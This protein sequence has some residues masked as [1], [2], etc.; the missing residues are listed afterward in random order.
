MGR[1]NRPRAAS[2]LDARHRSIRFHRATR[3]RA[4]RSVL[5]CV[6]VL[7]TGFMKRLKWSTSQVG[8]RIEASQNNGQVLPGGY[9]ANHADV[10][11]YFAIRNGAAQN[12]QGKQQA[13]RHRP[14]L[15][16]R[17]VRICR[18]NARKHSLPHPNYMG[19]SPAILLEM[20]IKIEK[21]KRKSPP[22]SGNARTTNAIMPQAA[23]SEDSP[24]M[25]SVKNIEGIQHA[26]SFLSNLPENVLPTFV[27]RNPA[28]KTFIQRMEVHNTSTTSS[29]T[30]KP[31]NDMG[32]IEQTVNQLQRRGL[33][34]PYLDKL[35]AY[36]SG[37]E[38]FSMD[39]ETLMQKVLVDATNSA[40]L[41]PRPRNG[42]FVQD[43]DMME[44]DANERNMQRLHLD[45]S[46]KRAVISLEGSRY[47]PI[48]LENL[49]L[50]PDLFRGLPNPF[51]DKPPNI[52]ANR[53]WHIFQ[54]PPNSTLGEWA[55]IV[56][57]TDP[58]PLQLSPEEEA[59]RWKMQ[60]SKEATAVCNHTPC[61][62]DTCEGTEEESL[63]Y[64]FRE[65]LLSGSGEQYLTVPFHF[66]DDVE[67]A[68]FY[69]A[70]LDGITIRELE[71]YVNP[72]RAQ[73]AAEAQKYRRKIHRYCQAM[74]QTRL[75]EGHL[76][77]WLY[78]PYPTVSP[79]ELSCLE[80]ELTETEKSVARRA[81]VI[82]VARDTPERR[83]ELEDSDTQT[84]FP[85]HQ[86][87]WHEAEEKI[88][89]E[90]R[91]VRHEPTKVSQEPSA[92]VGCSKMDQSRPGSKRRQV[93]FE[94][95]PWPQYPSEMSQSGRE[96]KRHK[97]SFE[98]EP[99]PQYP[100]TLLDDSPILRSGSPQM[101]TSSESDIFVDCEEEISLVRSSP[102]KEAAETSFETDSDEAML[103]NHFGAGPVL[104]SQNPKLYSTNNP[105]L[106]QGTERN[107]YSTRTD[108][109][110]EK[111]T[112]NIVKE[113]ESSNLTIADTLL[114]R[115]SDTRV[116]SEA[117]AP[118]AMASDAILASK[119]PFAPLSLASESM[120]ADCKSC[121]KCDKTYKYKGF[122]EKHIRICQ[123][124]GIPGEYPFPMYPCSACGKLYKKQG[125]LLTHMQF[126]NSKNNNSQDAGF[127]KQEM[128]EKARE[129]LVPFP[130]DNATDSSGRP[131]CEACRSEFTSKKELGKHIKAECMT[132]RVQGSY[133]RS[134][135]KQPGTPFALN[136]RQPM[137]ASDFGSSDVDS[138]TEIPSSKFTTPLD[139]YGQN[140]VREKRQST[141]NDD[142]GMDCG[143]RKGSI[144]EQLELIY[145][146]QSKY[147]TSTNLISNASFNF[148][149]NPALD[150]YSRT[151][152]A[153]NGEYSD[154]DVSPTPEPKS[155][156]IGKLSKLASTASS[157]RRSAGM[158]MSPS[159]ELTAGG[160]TPASVSRVLVLEPG[161]SELQDTK[162]QPTSRKLFSHASG[163]G[164]FSPPLSKVRDRQAPKGFDLDFPPLPDC[165]SPHKATAYCKRPSKRSGSYLNKVESLGSEVIT[166]QCLTQV[167]CD[168]I[169][170]IFGAIK[171]EEVRRQIVSVSDENG[172]TVKVI[173]RPGFDITR[174]RFDE[175]PGVFVDNGDK[176]FIFMQTGPETLGV[177]EG[178]D[179]GE[180]QELELGTPDEKLA[181]RKRG[182]NLKSENRK[183]PRRHR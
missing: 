2:R 60:L 77:S 114:N 119:T 41:T 160:G 156:N 24:T 151:N 177:R 149:E 162:L 120:A 36:S 172:L 118:T 176:T 59:F 39:A 94:E 11:G 70:A 5:K 154:M 1:V 123:G 33:V 43:V 80:L 98:E 174:V 112:R 134:D 132:L 93:S 54:R 92:E 66:K 34:K 113:A 13:L 40:A 3:F 16:T 153:K 56:T 44:V 15:S 103:R 161:L 142:S 140:P 52:V 173:V 96:S 166:I 126:C 110:N 61:M 35:A 108:Q 101:S 129:R 138:M 157:R 55:R 125:Y 37:P 179:A 9:V 71:F 18:R 87:T 165:S 8:H 88:Y 178:K 105:N 74:Q 50:P 159:S 58:V 17:K 99:W 51:L 69:Q 152:K 65:A 167:I 137:S 30:E 135:R 86:P 84:L 67:G 115:V 109:A 82:A 180:K 150:G 91:T 158:G 75:A 62:L 89:S 111:S 95:K 175:L 42:K 182:W 49:G 147:H 164:V 7:P 124:P 121:P 106:L 76:D 155:H 127:P 116:P 81:F 168:D 10:S 130:R 102:P 144:A 21:V 46:K 68:Q 47:R 19:I 53:R 79:E 100:G 38:A 104:F 117:S 23:I 64:P 57:T 181:N 20:M 85:E 48:D 22:V 131:L 27:Q 139:K 183:K 31:K 28:L 4:F 148:M 26:L 29:H 146:Q 163:V 145:G 171:E 107:P 78:L 32:I 45:T 63:T 143:V 136:F 12:S 14:L 73:Q 141:K 72:K 128:G 97:V 169:V 83:R 170:N 6:E 90:P 122:F 25:I 133:G